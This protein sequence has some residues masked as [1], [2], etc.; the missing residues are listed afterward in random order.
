MATNIKLGKKYKDSVTGFEGVATAQ[1]IFQFGCIRFCL[2]SADLKDGK[3]VE[4]WFDEQRLVSPSK[5]RAETG[6]PGGPVA[7]RRTTG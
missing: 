5:S 1:T 3:P 2:E 6:G 7:T 4:C